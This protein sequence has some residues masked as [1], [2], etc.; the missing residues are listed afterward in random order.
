MN[1][2]SASISNHTFCVKRPLSSS[3]H[4]VMLFIFSGSENWGFNDSWIPVEETGSKTM[5][6]KL[7]KAPAFPVFPQ[8]RL[9]H[10]QALFRILCCDKN[11]DSSS[12]SS[13]A[14]E[15]NKFRFK[16]VGRSLGDSKWKFNDIDASRFSVRS[17]W[18]NCCFLV[19]LVFDMLTT[20]F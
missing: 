5:Y 6:C 12:S 3:A 19:Y 4:R 7:G 1:I 13:S 10:H 15:N 17:F 18:F 14:P 16:L 11:S 2:L 8:P 20:E 9:H